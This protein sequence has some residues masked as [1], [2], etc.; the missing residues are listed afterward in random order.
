MRDQL[1]RSS[2]EPLLILLGAVALVLLVACANVA[3]LLLARGAAR[4]HE[5]AV[6]RA[7]GGGRG[8]LL[9]QLAIEHMVLALAGGAAGLLMAWWSIGILRTAAAPYVPRID[10]LSIDVRVLAVT[11]AVSLAAAVLFGVV[12]AL[13]L[14]GA[15]ANDTLKEGGRGMGSARARRVTR[16]RCGIATGSTK[17]P[18]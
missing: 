2:R 1:T 15:D 12:P 17:P 11:A 9:R 16:V 6:R 18:L 3:N 7:L 10:E 5:F 14:S 4:Q 13:R 8:R